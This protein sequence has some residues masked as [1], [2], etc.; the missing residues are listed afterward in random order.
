[1]V[2]PIHGETALEGVDVFWDGPEDLESSAVYPK[3]CPCREL[4]G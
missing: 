2:T 3:G 1:M 4:I